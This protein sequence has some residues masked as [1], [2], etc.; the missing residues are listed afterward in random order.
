MNDSQKIYSGG[1]HCGA[2]KFQVKADQLLK[3]QSCN[4]SIC[5]NTG[6]LHL[7]VPEKN[8][9][10]L[11]GKE[12]LSLYQFNSNVAKHYFCQ[13][14]G[15]KS[16]YIPRSNPDG[17]S[18]NVRCL[19]PIPDNVEIEAFDGQNWELNAQELHHLSQQP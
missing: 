7:I 12:D 3:V 9:K 15:I 5:I 13:K 17:I 18:V 11:Q 19:H 8:F 4:C 6:Y 14:C 16:F 10:L 2:I 1:C